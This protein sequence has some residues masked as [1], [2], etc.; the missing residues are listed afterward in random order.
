MEE[1]THTKTNWPV[2]LAISAA[3]MCLVTCMGISLAVFFAPK[4]YEFSLERSSLEGVMNFGLG[5]ID[6]GDGKAKISE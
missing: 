5:M 1:H 3:G 6:S 2:I 4:I